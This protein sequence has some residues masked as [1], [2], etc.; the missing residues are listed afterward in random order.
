MIRKRTG[1]S[2]YLWGVTWKV[3][4]Q[5]QEQDQ[6]RQQQEI[7][8]ALGREDVY[9]SVVLHF[10]PHYFLVN[11]G[12]RVTIQRKIHISVNTTIPVTTISSHDG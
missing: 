7:F 5:K 12:I 4:Q 10:D 8:Q 1:K 11:T 3:F 9:V 6:K 2:R